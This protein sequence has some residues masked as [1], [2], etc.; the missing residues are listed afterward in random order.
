MHVVKMSLFGIF[1]KK[2]NLMEGKGSGKL[3]YMLGNGEYSIYIFSFY[4]RIPFR[5]YVHPF[6]F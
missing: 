3:N 6:G 2:L 1:Y 5:V 4:Q